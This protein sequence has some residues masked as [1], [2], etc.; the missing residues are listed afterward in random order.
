MKTFS[1]ALVATVATGAMAAASI[2]P[3]YARHDGDGIGAGEIIAG[4]LVIGGIAAVAASA[5]NDRYDRGDRGDRVYRDRSGY[6]DNDRYG[7]RDGNRRGNPR[8]AVEMCIRAAENTASR[9]SYG[10]A[11]VT[12]IRD[13]D[14][15]RGGFTV[16]GRIAVNSM[17]RSW[18]RG[19]R[20]YGRGWGGDYRGWN[21]NYR[22][23]DAGRFTCDVRYGRVVDIDFSGI[24]GL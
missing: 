15:D 21:N 24:R 8:S 6:R 23:Y 11:D 3:A 2:S 17:G 14:W 12:D 10:R 20:D 1:K 5:D 16:K 9:F 7:Y 22:G 18:H 13:V 4:A 19:D